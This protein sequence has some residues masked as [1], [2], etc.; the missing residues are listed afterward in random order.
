MY[1]HSLG[2]SRALRRLQASE[3]N[4]SLPRKRGAVAESTVMVN[5]GQEDEGQD[6]VIPPWRRGAVVEKARMMSPGRVRSSKDEWNSD[7][8]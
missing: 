4:F 5:H 6:A 1:K 8:K 2:K 7:F 3:I